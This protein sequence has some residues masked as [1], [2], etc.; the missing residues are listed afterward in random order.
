MLLEQP[1]HKN[2]ARMKLGYLKEMALIL[3]LEVQEKGV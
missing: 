1:V 2:T 3:S